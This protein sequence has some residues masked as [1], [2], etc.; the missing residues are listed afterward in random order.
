M[1][2]PEGNDP[3]EDAALFAEAGTCDIGAGEA[4]G[5]EANGFALVGDDA[6]DVSGPLPPND[7]EGK[8]LFAGNEPDEGKPE[9]LKPPKPL[10]PKLLGCC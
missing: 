3:K 4:E 2:V 10:P 6:N 7:D 1:F 8:P 5:N 9:L